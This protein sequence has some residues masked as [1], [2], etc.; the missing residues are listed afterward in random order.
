MERKRYKYNK[1]T[2]VLVSLDSNIISVSC[3]SDDRG[4]M[5]GGPGERGDRSSRT[6]AYAPEN[7]APNRISGDKPNYNY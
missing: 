1:P 2:M 5:P 3:S 7:I 4:N 6:N